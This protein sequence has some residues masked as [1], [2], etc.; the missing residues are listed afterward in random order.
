MRRLAVI[1]ALVDE[2][3][4][5][6]GPHLQAALEVWRYCEGSA[7]YVFG[8]KLGH[9]DADRLRD[10][11]RGVGP[12]GMSRSDIR[13]KFG[14]RKTASDIEDARHVLGDAGLAIMFTLSTGGRP[15]ERWRTTENVEQ[16][17]ETGQ[18]RPDRVLS[19]VSSTVSEAAA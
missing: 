12:A 8:D 4:V 10:E 1:Y 14:G 6:K 16:T 13:D 19:S 5:V 2:D 17:Y 18:T 9:R 11:L 3:R 15:Q 7:R